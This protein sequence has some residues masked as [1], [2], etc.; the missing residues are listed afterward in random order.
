MALAA[1]DDSLL[2]EGEH[3]Q[4]GRHAVAHDVDP[5]DVAAVPRAVVG[6][7]AQDEAQVDDRGLDPCLWVPRL[8]YKFMRVSVGCVWTYSNEE[9][10]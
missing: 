4:M 1:E 3:D 10:L 2:G 7:P 8:L 9:A 5:V 6:H